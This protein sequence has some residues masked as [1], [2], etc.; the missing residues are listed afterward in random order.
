MKYV[1]YNSNLGYYLASLDMLGNYKFSPVAIGAMQF[2]TKKQA[3]KYNKE[4]CQSL[5][6]I[7]K[8]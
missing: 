2:D 4:K 3:E 1:L 5:L 6:W 7:I 8:V